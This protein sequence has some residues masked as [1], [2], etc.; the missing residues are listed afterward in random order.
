MRSIGEETETGR[1]DMH[2][3]LF[4]FI[5]VCLSMSMAEVVAFASS[6]ICPDGQEWVCDGSQAGGCGCYPKKS[7]F[8]E[9]GMSDY[10]TGTDECF[11][12]AATR[13]TELALSYCGSG[14]LTQTTEWQHSIESNG[15]HAGIDPTNCV[16]KC[17]ASAWFHCDR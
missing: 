8:I 12:M 11:N 5:F 6:A 16:M 10:L 13:A 7:D 14:R 1:T 9:A 2:R 3:I 15:C 4:L 17:V